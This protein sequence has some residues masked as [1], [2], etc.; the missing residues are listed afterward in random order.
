MTSFTACDEP[1]PECDYESDLQQARRLTRKWHAAEPCD[2]ATFQHSIQSSVS[3]RA[4]LYPDFC[5]CTCGPFPRA[6]LWKQFSCGIHK[7]LGIDV[8]TDRSSEL[9]LFL[10]VGWIEP[11]R[12]ADVNRKRAPV[13]RMGPVPDLVGPRVVL[14]AELKQNLM[15][16]P[17]L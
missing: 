14:G 7:Q 12:G 8:R 9:R 13:L 4:A 5:L 3:P 16:A 6:H 11:L 1:G 2:L 15:Q 17:G 10:Q